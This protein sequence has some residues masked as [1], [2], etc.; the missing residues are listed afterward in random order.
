MNKCNNQII[1]TYIV[2][3]IL[4]IFITV[5]FLLYDSIISLVLIIPFLIFIYSIIN[6]NKFPKFTQKELLAGSF[7]TIVIIIAIPFISFLAPKI[8]NPIKQSKI[9]KLM[10]F[11]VIIALF[12][13]IP[14]MTHPD[15]VCIWRH[16]RIGLEIMAIILFIYILLSYFIE[17]KQNTN[18]I[19]NNQEIPTDVDTFINEVQ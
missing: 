1:I 4:W 9:D 6:S 18:I 11:T 3:I 5:L 16:C 19:Q 12:S 7:I 17:L 8:N 15:D 2:L 14:L 10:I 13:L